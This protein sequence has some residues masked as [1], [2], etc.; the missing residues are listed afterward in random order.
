[1]QNWFHPGR[2]GQPRALPE[3]LQLTLHYPHSFEPA[4]TTLC[5][6]FYFTYHFLFSYYSSQFSS[7]CLRRCCYLLLLGTIY[8]S[9]FISFSLS[10]FSFTYTATSPFLLPSLTFLL[11]PPPLSSPTAVALFVHHLACSRYTFY[12]QSP[13]LPFSFPYTCNLWILSFSLSLPLLSL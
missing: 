12:V 10:I 4:I 11:A 3:T 8:A 2:P 9:H 6:A 7:Y 5:L 1:M 13:H